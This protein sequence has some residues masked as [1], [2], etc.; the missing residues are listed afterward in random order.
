MLKASFKNELQNIPGWRTSPKLVVFESDDWGM[1]RMASKAAYERLEK[2]G[3]PV[4]GCPFNRNDALENNADMQLFAEALLSVRDSKDRPAKFTLNN[5]VANPDFERIRES[6]FTRYSHEPFTETLA[7]Y[8]D[9]DRVLDQYREGLRSGVFSLQFH[10]REHIQVRHWL[11]ALRAENPLFVDAF[12]EQMA[13]QSAG[14]RSSCRIECLD[15][16]GA[17]SEADQPFIEQSVVEGLNLF[18]QIW[19]FRASSVIAPCY[20]WRSDLERIWQDQGIRFI[21]SGRAQR[22][23]RP[24][25]QR[26]SF[27]RHWMGRRNALGQVITVRNAVFEPSMDPSQDW[28][29]SCLRQIASAFR[30]RKPAIVSSHRLNF[31]GSIRPANR[32]SGLRQLRALLG[33]IVR[34]WPEVEFLGSEELGECIAAD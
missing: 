24:G 16:M 4:A 13:T 33:E 30:W 10:G 3:Y 19:G 34:R 28:L 27:K 29:G 2:K 12:S 22:V 14:P 26:P 23:P 5:I 8:P 31:I 1:I 6:G 17:Y 32:D 21:Q 18:Q 9:S 25:E 7:R 15:G 20:T 11:E